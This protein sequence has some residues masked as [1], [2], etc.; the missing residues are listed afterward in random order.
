LEPPLLDELD[1]HPRYDIMPFVN[2][3]VCIQ[4]EALEEKAE[5]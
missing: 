1:T 3:S 4:K 5:K 2:I